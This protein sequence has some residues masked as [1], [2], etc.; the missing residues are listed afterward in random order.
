M[1]L[2]AACG[3]GDSEDPLAGTDDDATETDDTTDTDSE[4][5]DAGE[6]GD[7][8]TLTWWHNSNNEPGQ[9]FYEEVAADFEAMHEGLTIEIEAMEHTDMVD[10]LAVS[11][12]TAT[13]PMSS[14]SAGAARWPPRSKRV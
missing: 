12:Q 3:N 11:W 9:G 5:D 13:T 2:V 1:A 10:R 6:S 14:W 4:T 8:V 7:A